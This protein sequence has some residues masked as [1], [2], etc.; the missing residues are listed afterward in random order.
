MDESC[1]WVS[2]SSASSAAGEVCGCGVD[3]IFVRRF[4]SWKINSRADGAGDVDGGSRLRLRSV[5]VG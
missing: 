5:R 1:S 2:K 4:G 3:Q